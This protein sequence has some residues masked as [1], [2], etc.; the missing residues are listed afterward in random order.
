MRTSAYD[1]SSSTLKSGPSAF[2]PSRAASEAE[3]VLPQ[4]YCCAAPFR[5]KIFWG[6]VDMVEVVV[7][8]AVVVVESVVVAAFIFLADARDG[9]LYDV[10]RAVADRFDQIN[11]A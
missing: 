2:A 11:S 5:R 1:L 9:G 6:V 7:S 10:D 4:S 3:P 8:C